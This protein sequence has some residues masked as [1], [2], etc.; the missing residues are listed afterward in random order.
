MGEG[1]GIQDSEFAGY[2]IQRSG[3]YD[4]NELCNYAFDF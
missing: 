4:R 3:E 1:F 2:R